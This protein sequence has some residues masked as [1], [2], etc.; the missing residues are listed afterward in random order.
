MPLNGILR[1]LLALLLP[2]T[3]LTISCVVGAGLFLIGRWTRQIRRVGAM[4]L[5]IAVIGFSAVLLLPVDLWLL[6]PLED[7]F[8]PPSPAHIDGVV[9]LGGAISTEVSADRGVPSLNRDADR[10]T[11]FAVLARTYPEARL[12]FAGGPPM[13]P[14]QGRLSEAEASGR[15]FEQLGVLPSR[16]LYDDRSQSTWGN[17]L[18]SLTLANPKPGETWVL[19]TSASHMPR[20]IGAFHR[21]GWPQILP[22]PVAYRT[23]K[24]GWRAP[25]QP[26]GTK[27][28]A[29]DLAAHEWAGLVGYW[30]RDRTDQLFP[31]P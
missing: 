22:W 6:R 31:G 16:V 8:P 4:L 19:I 3:F 27:L 21:A 30:L 25:L 15:L 11:A 24:A 12:V 20:A 7:R 13:P 2:S 29:I 10:L 26:I 28:A 9:V 23:T 14:G 18:N 17:A 5:S 1:L